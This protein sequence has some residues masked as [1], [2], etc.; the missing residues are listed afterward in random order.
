MYFSYLYLFSGFSFLFVIVC[1]LSRGK[2]RRTRDGRVVQTILRRGGTGEG[3]APGIQLTAARKGQSNFRRTGERGI[4]SPLGG[5]TDP[6]LCR[7]H[8]GNCFP[9]VCFGIFILFVLLKQL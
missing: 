8:S 6:F 4:K 7:S 5:F 2:S 9:S 1:S 3:R